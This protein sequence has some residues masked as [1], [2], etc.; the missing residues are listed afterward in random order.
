MTVLLQCTWLTYC[1]E[2]DWPTGV[3]MTD[4]LQWGWLTYC[5]ED[6]WPTAVKMTNLLQWG[7]LTYCSEEDW[8]TT[9]K[10]TDLLQW[11]PLASS[12]WWSGG[13]SRQ[14]RTASSTPDTC[15]GTPHS[16]IQLAFELGTVTFK[17]LFFPNSVEDTDSIFYMSGM[18]LIRFVTDLDKFA[19][20]TKYKV[21]L[22]KAGVYAT[23]SLARKAFYKKIQ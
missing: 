9:V 15:S 11:S 5:S 8:P 23:G 12:G 6:D 16:N 1:S 13:R 2:D 7:W 14:T 4:L 21:P 22:L 10:K 18:K 3:K 20:W 19:S 17:N